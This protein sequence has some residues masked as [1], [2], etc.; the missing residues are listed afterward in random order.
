[1]AEVVSDK[2]ANEAF[3]AANDDSDSS[4]ALREAHHRMANTLALLAGAL[5]RD[6][7]GVADPG[8]RTIL[9]RHER[10]IVDFGNLHRYFSLS[11]GMGLIAVEDYVRPL[12]EGLVGAVLAPL[13]IRCEAFIG[14]GALSGDRCESIGLII[15]ELVTNAAKHAFPNGAG[16]TVRIDLFERMDVW[17]CVVSDDG[18]GRCGGVAGT[19]SRILD[20]LARALNGRIE[21][22][23][24][25]SG[26]VVALEFPS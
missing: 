18:A 23:S 14:E 7:S 2:Q 20:M 11:P 5:R 15:A 25:P 16:G 4:F 8:V 12:C 24:A 13:G 26:T 19:G 22:R 3:R 21:F 10:R 6:L 9:R 17:H 1:M